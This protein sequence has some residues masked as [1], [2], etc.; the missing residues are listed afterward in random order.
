MSLMSRYLLRQ[1][2]FLML[3]VLG[4]GIGLY[5]LSDLFDRLDDFLEA[6]V[7]AKVAI[8]YF[9]V[10]TPLIISQILPAVFLIA[11]ILQLCI[12]ARSRELV[13]LQA[14]GISFLRLARFFFVCGVVWAIAQLAFSQFLGVQ[15][16]ELAARI[17]KEDVRK[18]SIQDTEL[19]RV[20]FT[21]SEYIIQLG[22]VVPAKRKG[23][24]ITAY[25]LSK[26]GKEIRQVLKARSFTARPGDWTLQNVRILDPGMLTTGRAETYSLPL[27]QDVAAFQVVDPRADLQKLPLWKLWTA[28]RQLQ[29]TGSNVEALRPA[30]HMKLAYACSVMVMG[31]ISLMLVTWNDNL[32]ICI[33]TGLLLTFMYY[34]FFTVGGTLGEKGIVSPI[35]GAWGADILFGGLALARILW[36]TR[37]RGK[38]QRKGKDSRRRWLHPKR[39]NPIT[40]HKGHPDHKTGDETAN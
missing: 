26:D 1:N 2:L 18:K 17:W 28:T 29:A 31:L 33:G 3:M 23:L 25:E 20:W 21:E 11:C 37:S 14:G 4:V 30:L 8:T 7:S 27:K 12:M 40:R 19:S 35:I 22:S 13:A 34:A 39:V 15:G 16:E 5:L 32:Y 38:L 10:K 24:N 6:G 9:V 36:S